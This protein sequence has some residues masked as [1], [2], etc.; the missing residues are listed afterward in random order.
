MSARGGKIVHRWRGRGRGRGQRSAAGDGGGQDQGKETD[1][2][3]IRGAARGGAVRCSAVRCGAVRCNAVRCGAVW[4]N[5][6]S[7]RVIDNTSL[8]SVLYYK[9][10][11]GRKVETSF[12]TGSNCSLFSLQSCDAPVA[13]GRAIGSRKDALGNNV[14]SS[15]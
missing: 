2:V 15:D 11:M 8:R 13:V 4:W 10:L 12:R 1:V 5:L 14:H 9:D 3:E 7:E 6:A